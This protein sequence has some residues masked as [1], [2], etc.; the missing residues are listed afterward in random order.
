MKFSVVT[1]LL[2]ALASA[3]YFAQEEYESGAVM[4]RMMERKE[5]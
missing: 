2:P 1:A 5:V 3:A 4:D